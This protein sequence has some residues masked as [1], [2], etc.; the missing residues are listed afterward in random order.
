MYL[1]FE[2]IIIRAVLHSFFLSRVSHNGE[3]YL[4]RFLMRQHCTNSSV[5]LILLSPLV[6]FVRNLE[7]RICDCD[8][9]ITC[10]CEILK[11]DCENGEVLD[12]RSGLRCF[13]GTGLWAGM[14]R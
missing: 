5:I 6:A 2:L 10:E 4:E 13:N 1:N 9:F 3:F 8:Q 7:L 14:A 11:C 12:E